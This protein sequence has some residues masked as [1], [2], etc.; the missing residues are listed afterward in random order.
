VFLGRD[1]KY[2]REDFAIELLLG[3]GGEGGVAHE[4]FE[5]QRAQSPRGRGVE[6]CDYE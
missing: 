3:L 4:H 5:A 1:C 2:L 6:K